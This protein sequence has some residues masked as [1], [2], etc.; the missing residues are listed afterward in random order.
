MTQ[1]TRQEAVDKQTIRECERRLSEIPADREAARQAGDI[2]TLDDLEEEEKQI[3]DYLDKAR[4]VRGGSRPLAD[5]QR[6]MFN[7]V[8]QAIDRAMKKIASAQ[9]PLPKLH[10]H[11]S[12]ALDSA[13]GVFEYRPAPSVPVWEL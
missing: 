3:N 11:L 8:K 10:E 2:E 4:D 12:K 7:S 1:Q 9:P 6:S 5:S 13:N